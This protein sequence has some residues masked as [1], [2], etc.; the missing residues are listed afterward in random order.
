M[1]TPVK[2]EW[3]VNGRTYSGCYGLLDSKEVAKEH[4]VQVDED[5]AHIHLTDKEGHVFGIPFKYINALVA[6]SDEEAPQPKEIKQ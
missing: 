3:T 5:G 2:I 1:S 4:L 6:D